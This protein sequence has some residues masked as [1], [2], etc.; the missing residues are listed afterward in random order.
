VFTTLSVPPERTAD[1]F[2]LHAPL[3][4]A[5]RSSLLG[6]ASAEAR[7]AIQQRLLRE[8]RA[9]AQEDYVAALRARASIEIDKA[10]VAAVNP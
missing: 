8:K 5:A 3:E 10:A 9:R 1:S 7:P 6:L 2:V 4:L